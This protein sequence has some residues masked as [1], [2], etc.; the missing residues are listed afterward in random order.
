MRLTLA[1]VSGRTGIAAET[2]SRIET[3]ARQPSM[4]TAQ[5]VLDGLGMTAEQFFRP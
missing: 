4:P 1:E 3:G 2:L 5:R